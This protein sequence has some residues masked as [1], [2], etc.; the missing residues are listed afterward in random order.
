MSYEYKQLK[1][2]I[3]AKFGTR[4]AFADAL[5]VSENTVSRKLNG[6]S[7]FSQEDI[8]KW[9]ELLDIPVKEYGKYFFA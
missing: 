5:G 2:R 3:T 7:A 4:K 9:A 1:G 6:H 8:E